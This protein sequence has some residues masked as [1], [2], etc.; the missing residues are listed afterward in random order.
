M[1]HLVPNS[2]IITVPPFASQTQESCQRAWAL[3]TIPNPV[4]ETPVAPRRP[5]STKHIQS[6]HSAARTVERPIVHSFAGHW[7]D[8]SRVPGRRNDWP[9]TV[10]WRA[11]DQRDSGPTRTTVLV[12]RCDVPEPTSPR[13]PPA[14]RTEC[15]YQT[16]VSQKVKAYSSKIWRSFSASAKGSTR[17]PCAIESGLDQCPDPRMADWRDRQPQG[18]F[19]GSS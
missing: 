11:S 10:R 14:T 8:R 13:R 9:A 2:S 1:Q 17:R 16:L 15:R 18:L 7:A 12:G 4:T 3:I 19:A 5:L 6:P